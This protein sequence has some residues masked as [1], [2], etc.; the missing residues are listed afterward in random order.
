MCGC[1]LLAS[2]ARRLLGI[3]MAFLWEL[4]NHESH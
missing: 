3:A 1:L 2:A 4:P